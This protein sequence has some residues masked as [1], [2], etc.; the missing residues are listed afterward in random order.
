[1]HLRM[2]MVIMR[3]A[4][5]VPNRLYVRGFSSKLSFSLAPSSLTSQGRRLLS[6][7]SDEPA[8]SDK[9]SKTK[10]DPLSI[11]RNKN[12][13]DDQ[14]FSAMSK[15]GGIKVTACTVRNLLNDLMIQHTMTKTPSDIL[16]RTIACSLLMANGIQDEQV[17]QITLQSDGPIRGVVAIASGTG[18]V[19]GYVGSPMLGDMYITEA[20]G[21]G[22]VQIVKNHPSWPRPYNGITSIVHGD[23]DRDI[24][25]YL[26]ES[27]Q[28][29]CALAA[30]THID[31]ILCKA[32]GGYLIERLPDVE[33]ET[34]AK[35]E[36]NLARLVE[37]DGGDA[38]PTNLLLNGVTPVDICEIILDGLDMQ[39]LQQIMPTLKCKCS[40]ERLI[41]SLRLL[42][43][44]EVDDILAK[45]EKVEA[46]CEFCSRI[47]RLS[48]DQVREKLQNASGDPSTDVDI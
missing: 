17:V 13:R 6:S 44:S 26:A 38:L 37:M 48:P 28:R 30:A 31:N 3:I 40:E 10:E 24:G 5:L 11:Y 15:D 25:L 20:M 23:V 8:S 1:M 41:R 22:S 27:E 33:Q 45:E 47:Y 21:K 34:V 32:A 14:V 39:P 2:I 35:V 9:S 36:A 43:R 12:N 42:P 16:G 29:S 19:R 46:R 4:F 7:L 18:E